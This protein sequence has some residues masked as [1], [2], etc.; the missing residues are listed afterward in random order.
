[1]DDNKII[2]ATLTN[3][4]YEGSVRETV[5]PERVIETYQTFRR[6]LRDQDKKEKLVPTALKGLAESALASAKKR[7]S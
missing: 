5:E 7:A 6:L 4:Y 1:M 3:A 2:A